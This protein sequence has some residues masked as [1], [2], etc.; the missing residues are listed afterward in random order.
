MHHTPYIVYSL[1]IIKILK[2]INQKEFLLGGGSSSCSHI[3]CDVHFCVI[4]DPSAANSSLSLH[5]LAT[6]TKEY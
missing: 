3:S 2:I 1:K 5:I 4:S 6:K